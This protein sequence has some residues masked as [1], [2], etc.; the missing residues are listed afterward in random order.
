VAQLKTKIEGVSFDA[1]ASLKS[2]VLTLFDDGGNLPTDPT[3]ETDPDGESELIALN[4]LTDD[5]LTTT[6]L[7]NQGDANQR[8]TYTQVIKNCCGACWGYE[9]KTKA[10]IKAGF[11]NRSP[12]NFM[13]AV[14]LERTG[15]EFYQTVEAYLNRFY[16]NGQA[17]DWEPNWE[18]EP[19]NGQAWEIATPVC[20]L[21][22]DVPQHNE[23]NSSTEAEDIVRPPSTKMV[24]LSAN[25]GYLKLEAD[26]RILAAYAWFSRKAIAQAWMQQIEFI[27]SAFVEMRKSLR[28]S[29]WKWELKI[30]GLNMVQVERLSK[31]VLYQKPKKETPVQ[32]AGIEPP[33]GWGKLHTSRVILNF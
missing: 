14:N 5:C 9:V 13:E 20:C 3:P 22:S 16:Y 15:K 6:D 1:I 10:D 21:L 4:G 27:P 18:L 11:I 26:G 24:H 17:C 28:N 30:T 25:C 31:E 8:L 19:L 29:S 7:D 2:A 33:P 32:A 12:L 23:E